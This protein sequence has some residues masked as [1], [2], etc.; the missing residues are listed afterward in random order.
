VLL[1]AVGSDVTMIQV[2]GAAGEVRDPRPVAT[3]EQDL[4]SQG[5]SVAVM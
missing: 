1:R 4:R 5:L 3:V 2:L